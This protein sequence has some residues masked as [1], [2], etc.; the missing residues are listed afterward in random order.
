MVRID[1]TMKMAATKESKKLVH[2]VA[3]MIVTLIIVW[4]VNVAPPTT[5]IRMAYLDV[6]PVIQTVAVKHVKQTIT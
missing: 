2:A 6:H 4:V 3:T 5:H 1:I